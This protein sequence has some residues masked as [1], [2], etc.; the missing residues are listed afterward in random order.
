MIRLPTDNTH[1]L[2][3]ASA[4]PRRHAFLRSLGIDFVVV[5]PDIDE[6]HHA[7]ESPRAYV[8]RLAREKCAA[9]RDRTATTLCVLAADTTVDLDGEV[10]GKPEH[11]GD[12]ATMLR[13]LS[14]RTHEV[15]SGLALWSGESML[16][17]VVST[18]VTFVELSESD[19]SWYVSTGEPVDKAGSYAIQGA[20]GAFVASITGSVSNVA[21]L[22]LAEIRALL[23]GVGIG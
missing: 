15:H 5:S 17:E 12:A 1:Q 14:G 19:I 16:S 7:G 13:R 20:G 22:P 10:L 11:D 8:E 3:L 23:K 18:L 6:S 4:S 2:V 21:G 9:A